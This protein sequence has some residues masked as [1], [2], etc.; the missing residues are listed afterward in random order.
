MLHAELSGKPAISHTH[1]M[2]ST[3]P[4]RF[5]PWRPFATRQLPFLATLIGSLAMAPSPSQAVEHKIWS[6]GPY[7][8]S[9]ELGDFRITDASGKGTR[10]DPIV[11]EEE[12]DSPAPVTLTV[13]TTRPLVPFDPSGDYASGQLYLRISA[14]NN[15]GEPWVEFE[16][17]LQ[18]AL[19]RLSDDA[20]GLSFDQRNVSP[21]NIHSADYG[22]FQREMRPYDRL[23]FKKG[24]AD[25]KHVA[26]FEFLVTD[27][28]PHLA[29]Y[30]VQEPHVPS[31]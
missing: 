24:H 19:G 12:L 23:V 7:S 2:C 27:Y 15:S 1:C 16:F 26:E 13:R 8:V 5:S 14:L 31:S 11:I 29:I 22:E 30:L 6:C 10:D 3:V 4:T 21:E 20:D 18:S 25:P 17:E 9:D 28:T